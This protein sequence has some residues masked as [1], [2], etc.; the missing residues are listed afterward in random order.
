MFSPIQPLMGS[1]RTSGGILRGRARGNLPNHADFITTNLELEGPV[2]G[3]VYLYLTDQYP[4][5]VNFEFLKGDSELV[6]MVNVVESM[7][8]ILDVVA[9]KF[10]II[11]GVYSFKLMFFNFLR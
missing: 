5:H 2:K 6:V 3:E 1:S 4:R 8:P 11:Q 10:S 7:G 9:R